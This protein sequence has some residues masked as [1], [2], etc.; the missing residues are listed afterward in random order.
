M[1]SQFAR[2]LKWEGFDGFFES[3][4]EIG[5]KALSESHHECY[6]SFLSNALNLSC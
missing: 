5:R 3:E 1:L 2:R 4:A 6:L